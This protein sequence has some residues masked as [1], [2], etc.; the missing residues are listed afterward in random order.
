MLVIEAFVVVVETCYRLLNRR[1]PY[2]LDGE[3]AP[4]RLTRPMAPEE[5]KLLPR[6]YLRP[7]PDGTSLGELAVVDEAERDW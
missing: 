7:E 6:G 3:P 5:A 2:S 4:D 1:L